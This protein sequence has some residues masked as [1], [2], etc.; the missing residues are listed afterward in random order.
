MGLLGT[1]CSFTRFRIADSVPQELWMNIPAKLKQFAFQ[2]IDDIPEERAWGWTSFEDMLDTQWR[3][4]LP[5]K[6]AYLAFALRL[7]TRRIP[8]AVLKKHVMIALREE[9]A[10]IK[11]QGKKFIARDRKTELRDQVKLRLLGRF[12]PI[13]A[14]FDVVWATDSNI[15]YLASTQSKLIELFMNHFTLTFDLHLEPLTPYA[16]AATLMDEASLSRLDNL[17][18]TSFV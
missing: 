8:P 18:P 1:S 2:D 4:A 13:P 11:E 15:V 7:D 12:L 9:E 3:S 14:I 10:R 16:L 17:E 6:G 5:E